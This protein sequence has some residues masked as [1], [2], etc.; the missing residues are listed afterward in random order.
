MK[1]TLDKIKK[2]T[3]DGQ[4]IGQEVRM[5]DVAFYILA[6]VFDD[7]GLAYRTIFDSA[8]EDEEV[9]IYSGGSMQK[10]IKS[11]MTENNSQAISDSLTFSENKAALIEMLN[12]INELEANNELSHKDALKY[13]T[14]IRVKLQDRFSVQ[15]EEKST[16]VVVPKKFDMICK[17]THR[18]C[19]QL[20]VKTAC[21]MLHLIPDP[22]YNPGDGGK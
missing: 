3:Y 6:G 10:F 7:K 14:D 4:Q 11:W 8:A 9:E 22:N 20:D 2:L 19:Y 15:D 18:E 12:E 16:I 21:E 13:K 17:H 1:L 5:R